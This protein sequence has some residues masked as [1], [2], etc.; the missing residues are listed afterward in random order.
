[1]QH[2]IHSRVYEYISTLVTGSD[3]N[4]L[5]EIKMIQIPGKLTNTKSLSHWV[6]L[7]LAVFLLRKHLLETL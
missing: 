1:M 3:S 2:V 4:C 6:R 5:P 7:T